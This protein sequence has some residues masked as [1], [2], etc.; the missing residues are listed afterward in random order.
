M[1]TYEAIV[2]RRSVR[3]F[4]DNKDIPKEVL[5][6]IV[7]AARL[8]P[9]ARNEQPWE[10]VVITGKDTRHRIA[11]AASPNGSFIANSA[12]CIAVFCLDTKYCL[13]DGCAATENILLMAADL[14]LGS[15][16]IAGDKKPYCG[17]IKKIL[18]MPEKYRLVS[19][20][21][22]GYPQGSPKVIPKRR[23][24]EVLHWERF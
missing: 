15:C 13:E 22:L 17:A 12:A 11:L 21:A 3:E 14:S 5:E 6:E 9:T 16:W 24:E 8:A 23:L 1:Q 20:I 10:F 4:L 18:G 7:D 2:K 19:L